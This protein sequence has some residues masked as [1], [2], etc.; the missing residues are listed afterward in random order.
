METPRDK[1][2]ALYRALHEE[3]DD[4][5]NPATEHAFLFFD[6]DQQWHERLCALVRSAPYVGKAAALI[7]S[8]AKQYAMSKSRRFKPLTTAL[9]RGVLEHVDWQRVASSYLSI[10]QSEIDYERKQRGEQPEPDQDFDRAEWDKRL[11]SEAAIKPPD[12]T[13][14]VLRAV[15]TDR[16]LF[17]NLVSYVNEATPEVPP[18]GAEP[19]EKAGHELWHG[20]LKIFGASFSGKV[21]DFFEDFLFEDAA[22]DTPL[23]GEMLYAVQQMVNWRGLADLLQQKYPAQFGGGEESP[24]K[25]SPGQDVIVNI[26]G[27]PP[28]GTAGKDVHGQTGSQRRGNEIEVEFNGITAFVPTKYLRPLEG[29]S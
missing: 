6:N 28:G 7:A 20:M 24:E 27:R 19:G 3:Q 10:V 26:P 4:D 17:Q 25:F 14:I 1:A 8:T 29:E 11:K 13:Q 21:A 15:E 12:L 22:A 16:T 23:V 9:I 18:E 2:A 5:V